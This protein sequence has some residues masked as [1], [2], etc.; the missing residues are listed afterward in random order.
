MVHF[1]AKH[2]N[3]NKTFKFPLHCQNMSH[4]I[5]LTDWFFFPEQMFLISHLWVSLST[6]TPSL[7]PLGLLLWEWWVPLW[8]L[9][10][11]FG[12]QNSFFVATTTMG[13]TLFFQF[14]AAATI[15]RPLLAI[16]TVFVAAT[17]K[18]RT[19]FRQVNQLIW[20]L[21]GPVGHWNSFFWPLQPFCRT[22]F[23]NSL[24]AATPLRPLNQLLGHSSNC[25]SIYL[26][27]GMVCDHLSLSLLLTS[28]PPS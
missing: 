16:E 18:G 4:K 6:G 21:Q 14:L 20:P 2:F 17:T 1:Y 11:P 27:V 9:Q 3:P 12:H 28:Y 23:F 5:I 19:L 26:L 22:P 24:A 15:F 13:R 25:F 10:D 7:E 8:P